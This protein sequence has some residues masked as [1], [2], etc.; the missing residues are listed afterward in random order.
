MLGRSGYCLQ[1]RS[2]LFVVNFVVGKVAIELEQLD[3]QS[4]PRPAGVA[5]YTA[6]YRDCFRQSIAQ[7][8]YASLCDGDSFGPAVCLAGPP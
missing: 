3:Q 1:M 2:S 6:L 4:A 5:E 7:N 8:T